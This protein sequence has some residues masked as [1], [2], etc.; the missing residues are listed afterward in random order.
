MNRTDVSNIQLIQIKNQTPSF[1]YEDFVAGF[2]P[3]LRGSSTTTYVRES[4]KN[5]TETSPNTNQIVI[6][7]FDTEQRIPETEL[8]YT[9]TSALEIVKNKLNE[10]IEIDDITPNLLF[11]W[12]SESNHFVEI[13]KIRVARILWAKLMKS[14][15][16]KKQSSLTS[17]VEYKTG[18]IA[19][20]K[21]SFDSYTKT[22][23][24][25]MSGIFGSVEIIDTTETTQQYLQKETQITRTVDPWAG[26]LHL[27][28][29]TEEIAEKTWQLIQE[30]EK[31][32][33]FSKAIKH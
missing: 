33:G 2:P 23:I 29:L 21:N 26:S 16:P 6:N 8:A 28:K 7:S 24:Q 17:V 27:E 19:D 12:K 15:N 11:Q 3:Y 4:W 10:G 25:T 13:A 30:I 9:L 32:G 18:I 14:F 20:T 22:T 5:K 31:K 1:K